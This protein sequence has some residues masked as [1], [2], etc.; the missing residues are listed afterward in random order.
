MLL[1]PR[2]AVLWFWFMGNMKAAYS[3]LLW[4]ALGFLFAPITAITYAWVYNS[5]QSVTGVEYVFIGVAIFI[6]LATLGGPA[7]HRAYQSYFRR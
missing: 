7:R 1:L 3:G 6:D 2:L 4:P 5:E